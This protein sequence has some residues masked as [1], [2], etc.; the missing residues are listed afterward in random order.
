MNY[1]KMLADYKDQ[2]KRTIIGLKNIE[3]CFN[4]SNDKIMRIVIKYKGGD[5]KREVQ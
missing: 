2:T 3:K 4:P 1:I 5:I